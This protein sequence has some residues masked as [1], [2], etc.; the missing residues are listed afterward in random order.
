MEQNK[1]LEEECIGGTRS[2]VSM[3]GDRKSNMVTVPSEWFAMLRKLGLPIPEKIRWI[4]GRVGIA[5]PEGMNDI[6]AMEHLVELLYNYYP[7][8]FVD[9][10]FQKVKQRRMDED[11]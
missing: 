11:E 10:I 2:I 5:I 3:G 1:L 4:M 8:G 6:E 7:E 9:S